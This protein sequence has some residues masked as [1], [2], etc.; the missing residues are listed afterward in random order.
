MAN[1][2]SGWE[3]TEPFDID[4][5]ELNGLSPQMCFSMGVE[6]MKWLSRIKSNST[7]SDMCMEGN[8]IRIQS[9]LERHGIQC[10]A[11]VPNGGWCEIWVNN[12]G[13]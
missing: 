2:E 5:G 4:D 7:H 9:L 12:H 11:R 6:W 10:E 8:S 13:R 1:Q 3:L